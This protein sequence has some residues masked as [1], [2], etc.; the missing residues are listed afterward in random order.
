MAANLKK[1]AGILE[2]PDL[3]RIIFKVHDAD[4]RFKQ[5][6]AA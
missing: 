6:G 4:F 2:M 1:L 3:D 5:T